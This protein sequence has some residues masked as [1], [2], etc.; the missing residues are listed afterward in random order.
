MEILKGKV[1]KG[2]GRGG[3]IG[4]P[5]LNIPYNGDLSGVFVARVFS[6]EKQY[7]AAAHIGPRPTFEDKQPIC[8]LHI[9]DFDG[10]L[11]LGSDLEVEFLEQIREV[12]KFDSV[13]DLAAQ[14]ALDVSFAK[15]W[16]NSMENKSL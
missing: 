9:L 12:Q 10:E 11:G 8:E 5:T 6:G 14:L 1:V 15:S 13:Q 2:D 4:F 3:V 7:P 16:Y